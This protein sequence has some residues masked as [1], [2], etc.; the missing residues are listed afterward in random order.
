MP[1]S[2]ASYNCEGCLGRLSI[3]INVTAQ[4]TSVIVPYNSEFIKLA[5]RPKKIPIVATKST[6]AIY[7][8]SS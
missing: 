3:W 7:R 1:S 2:S 5:I 4:G 6:I 8:K